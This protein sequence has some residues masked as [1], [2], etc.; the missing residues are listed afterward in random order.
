[1]QCKKFNPDPPVNAVWYE[2]L[3]LRDEQVEQHRLVEDTKKFRTELHKEPAV[4]NQYSTFL[5][6]FSACSDS[7]TPCGM[8]IMARLRACSNG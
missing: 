4:P 2:A 7:L 1:M 3:E 8:P 5:N 6:K